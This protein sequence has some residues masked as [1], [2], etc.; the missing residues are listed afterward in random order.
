MRWNVGENPFHV[1]ALG[2]VGIRYRALPGKVGLSV[3]GCLLLSYNCQAKISMFGK[4][5]LT[6]I[7]FA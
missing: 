3:L 2:G 5:L 7:A 6:F 4:C 1:A